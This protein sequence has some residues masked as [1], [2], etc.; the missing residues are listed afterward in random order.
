MT[1]YLVVYFTTSSNSGLA[2]LAWWKRNEHV[3]YTALSSA[4]HSCSTAAAV[5][6]ISLVTFAAHLR[7]QDTVA[8]SVPLRYWPLSF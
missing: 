1:V 3:G 8:T 2:V 7:T 4:I 5:Q 6:G